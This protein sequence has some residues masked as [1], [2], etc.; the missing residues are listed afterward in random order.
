MSRL[1]ASIMELRR[2]LLATGLVA[3]LIVASTS[4]F[5]LAREDQESESS[6]V[7]LLDP[8]LQDDGHD[9]RNASQHVMYTENIQPISFNSLT[10]PGNA[11]VQV[12]ESP[13]GNTYAISLV[14]VRCIL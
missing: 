12:A 13:D 4:M 5:L 11:E 3:C 2:I 9:H 6:K 14:G 1:L 10:A 8:L 7:M